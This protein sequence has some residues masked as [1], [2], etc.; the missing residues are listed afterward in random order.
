MVRIIVRLRLRQFVKQGRVFDD[1]KLLVNL[2][3][4]SIEVSDSVGIYAFLHI[5]R[6]VD[7]QNNTKKFSFT[8]KKDQAWS[9]WWWCDGRHLLRRVIQFLLLYLES[10]RS[11]YLS[12]D[13]E[14][15]I[16]LCMSLPEHESKYHQ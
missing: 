2:I 9:H 8:A 15:I 13:F 6:I 4:L 11:Q 1:E 14:T 5:A 12:Y 3:I 10:Q 7:W 16:W